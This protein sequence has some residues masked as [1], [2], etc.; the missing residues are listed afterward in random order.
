MSYMHA[1][2]VSGLCALFT[3]FQPNRVLTVECSD[4]TLWL[5]LKFIFIYSII[6]FLCHAG[7][8]RFN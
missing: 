2:N 3:S 1:Y 7:R 4:Y 6:V 8:H 5:N